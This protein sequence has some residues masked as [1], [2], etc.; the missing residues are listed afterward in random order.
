MMTKIDIGALKRTISEFE[1]FFYQTTLNNRLSN[2]QSAD[3]TFRDF[4]SSPRYGRI[5]RM[6]ETNLDEDGLEGVVYRHLTPDQK[7]TIGALFHVAD[8]NQDLNHLDE[9]SEILEKNLHKKQEYIDFLRVRD[10]LTREQREKLA[11]KLAKVLYGKMSEEE[12]R[13]LNEKNIRRYLLNV[14]FIRANRPAHR[15]IIGFI[16][17]YPSLFNGEEDVISQII[18]RYADEELA[19]TPVAYTSR[20]IRELRREIKLLYS[21]VK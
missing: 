9:K 16:K 17:N 19:I 4:I 15:E 3:L 10:L 1:D 14:G 5:R 18:E 11:S 6:L 20:R 2:P 8:N 12:K 21:S 7:K 13:L